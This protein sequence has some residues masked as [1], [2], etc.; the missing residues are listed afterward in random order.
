M[1]GSEINQQSSVW[2]HIYSR[3]EE[4]NYKSFHEGNMIDEIEHSGIDINVDS[5]VQDK[6]AGGENGT[7]TR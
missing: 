5:L 4:D 2:E 1:S 7:G 3:T 6:G